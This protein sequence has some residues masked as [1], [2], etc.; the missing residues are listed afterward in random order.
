MYMYHLRIEATLS[1]EHCDNNLLS[2]MVVTLENLHK[3]TKYFLKKRR[4]SRVVFLSPIK[5]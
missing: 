2:L 1:H 5:V 3:R 4:T